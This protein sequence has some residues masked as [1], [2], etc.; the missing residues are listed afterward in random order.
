MK[1]R[2]AV[3]TLLYACFLS[4]CVHVAHLYPVQGP[5]AAQTPLPIYTGRLTGVINSG[6]ISAKLANG[7]QFSGH[8]QGQSVGAL[9]KDSRAGVL[10]PFNLSAEWD[11]VY[12]PVSIG[13]KCWEHTCLPGQRLQARRA[14]HSSWR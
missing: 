12:G 4:G 14:E 5:L 10:P 11:A 8:W 6:S 1:A 3:V 9:A 2:F 13:L 7:Q